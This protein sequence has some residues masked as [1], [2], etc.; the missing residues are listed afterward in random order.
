ML[1][2]LWDHSPP[3][4]DEVLVKARVAL[5]LVALKKEVRFDV[6]LADSLPEFHYL[7]VM[8]EDSLQVVALVSEV[9]ELD[10]LWRQYVQL[11][12]LFI[13]LTTVAARRHRDAI[14]P[15]AR[16]VEHHC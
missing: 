2:L 8:H 14:I 4:I 11:F 5:L 6:E 1:V 3:P 13:P 16:H 10:T 15:E 12:H 9:L 7:N